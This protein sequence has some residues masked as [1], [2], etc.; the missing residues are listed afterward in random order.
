MERRFL[1]SPG[2]DGLDFSIVACITETAKVPTDRELG[3]CFPEHEGSHF[4]V[5]EIPGVYLGIIILYEGSN[6]STHRVAVSFDP[7][8]EQITG[9]AL[10]ARYSLGRAPTEEEARRHVIDLRNR[11]KQPWR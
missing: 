6:R 5:K 9:W 8:S 1:V 3:L 2:A 7:K 4:D 10:S 11:F